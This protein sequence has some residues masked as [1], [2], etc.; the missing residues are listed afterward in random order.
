MGMERP[1]KPQKRTSKRPGNPPTH[2]VE[3]DDSKGGNTQE[4]DHGGGDCFVEESGVC[5]LS[6]MKAGVVQIELMMLI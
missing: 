4:V 1:C 3:N 5:F 2:P 6:V